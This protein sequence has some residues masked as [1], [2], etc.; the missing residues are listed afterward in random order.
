MNNADDKSKIS[1]ITGGRT[2]E[3]EKMQEGWRKVG[4]LKSGEAVYCSAA[5]VYAKE[6]DYTFLIEMT[7]EEMIEY[8]KDFPGLRTRGGN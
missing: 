8:I 5:G 7:G 2:Q 1:I 6:K 3:T 4:M